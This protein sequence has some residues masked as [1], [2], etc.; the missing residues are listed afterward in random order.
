MRSRAEVHA[1][2]A[3]AAEGGVVATV[4]ERRS[5]THARTVVVAVERGGT[6]LLMAVSQGAPLHREAIQVLVVARP[7]QALGLDGL[8]AVTGRVGVRHR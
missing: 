1:A 5:A 8:A 2:Q 3:G 6:A 4:A 7:A